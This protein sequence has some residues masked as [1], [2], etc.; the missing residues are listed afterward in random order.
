MQ[1]LACRSCDRR[2]VNVEAARDQNLLFVHFLFFYFTYCFL[3]WSFL[4]DNMITPGSFFFSF[5]L[6][7]TQSPSELTLPQRHVSLGRTRWW[8]RVGGWNACTSIFFLCTFLGDNMQ[9]QGGKRRA[10]CVCALFLLS[11]HSCIKR[12]AAISSVKFCCDSCGPLSEQVGPPDP[13]HRQRTKHI[14]HRRE[15]ADARDT[16]QPQTV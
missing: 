2:A 6:S 4:F 16:V 14:D 10:V 7:N 8:M 12:F 5:T 9:Y 11:T 15:S 1:S 3:Q 13:L